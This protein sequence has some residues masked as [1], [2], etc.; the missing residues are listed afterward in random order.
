MSRDTKPFREKPVPLCFPLDVAL[1]A[2]SCCCAWPVAPGPWPC[3][4]CCCCSLAPSALLPWCGLVSLAAA[5]LALTCVRA[6]SANAFAG[7]AYARPGPAL[8]EA[9][10]QQ[11][12]W[13]QAQIPAMMLACARCSGR[14]AHRHR[15][16]GSALVSG[17]GRISQGACRPRPATEL[18]HMRRRARTCGFFFVT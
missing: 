18:R 4:P 13:P 7:R 10:L 14:S 1:F 15:V 17:R 8:A 2:L 3:L 6:A 16:W 5:L 12:E 11:A 9:Q